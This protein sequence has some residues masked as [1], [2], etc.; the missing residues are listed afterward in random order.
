MSLEDFLTAPTPSITFERV[1]HTCHVAKPPDCFRS[2]T[3]GNNAYRTHDTC[4][5]C[6][7]A[8]KHEQTKKW[9]KANPDSVKVANAKWHQKNKEKRHKQG[10]EWKENNDARYRKSMWVRQGIIFA[11]D[12]DFNYWYTRWSETTH[13]EVSGLPFDKT[14]NGLKCLDHDYQTGRPRGVIRS[15]INVA[16]GLIKDD[17]TILAQ[18]AAYLNS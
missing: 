17:H 7:I 14:R 18:M 8:H 12:E 11:D 10:R 16:I 13:C 4:I 15:H 5:D 1:C 6:T 2:W 3:T 9:H